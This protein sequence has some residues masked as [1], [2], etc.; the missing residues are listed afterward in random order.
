MTVTTKEDMPSFAREETH[1]SRLTATEMIGGVECR[2][3]LEK[4]ASGQYR[5][6]ML[7]PLAAGQRHQSRF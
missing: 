6:V 7:T 4:D 5:E 3:V 2:I 1:S